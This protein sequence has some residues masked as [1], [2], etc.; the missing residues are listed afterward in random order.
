MPLDGCF[1]YK[2]KN[3]LSNTL[4]GSRVDKIYQ[5]S[6]EELVFLLRSFGASYKLLIS[7]VVS[8]P[9]VNIIDKTPEN[10]LQPPMFCML[11][12]KHFSS[13]KLVDIKQEELERILTF[14][15]ETK[16]E[17][18][19][20]VYPTLSV[21][22]IGNQTNIVL[23]D[24]NMRI[25]DC[26]RRSDI[27]SGTRLLQPGA[28]Y[29]FPERRSKLCILNET[30]EDIV[31]AV[32]N[33]GGVL[34][35]ALLNILS[36]V[37]PLVCREIAF[38]AYGDDGI[39]VEN[40]TD[41]SPLI[42]ELSNLKNS[43]MSDSSGFIIESENSKKDFSFI[44]IKQY[45]EKYKNICIQG[46]GNTLDI[47]YKERSN[48]ARINSLS[49]ELK[50]TLNNLK[51]RTER[52]INARILDLKKCEEREKYRIYGEL[53]KANLY[54]IERGSSLVTVQNYYDENYGLIDIKLNP[55][56]SPAENA[57]R[58]F[59]EYKKLCVA[60][61]T[62]GE[63]IKDGENELFYIESMIESLSRAS[64]VEELNSIK[65]EAAAAGYIRQKSVRKPKKAVLK[66]MEF[67]SPD[68][69]T[70]LVGR[71][72]REND[73]LTFK[74]AEKTDLWL[75]TKNIPGSHVVVLTEAKQV[76]EETVIFAARLAAKYSK[77]K[78]SSNVPVDCVPIKLVKK[79]NGAKP[80]MVIFTGN[81]TLFVTPHN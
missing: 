66:P 61:Q 10:P 60:H 20:T 21:E 57:G 18:G 38:S 59:K 71:N 80:G 3:E 19:D 31:F 53:L 55:T 51:N 56:L 36:G 6:K 64:T 50:K 49:S 45:G 16:N 44:E 76:P 34:S 40:I 8:A 46:I 12:R 7:A 11:L 63:L 58:Y 72:N 14:C 70:V 30:A 41:F 67:S 79:P 65:E 47:F 81:K 77:A 74:I 69:F 26:V 78:N 39:Y 9:R 32:K 4:L 52:K 68:G 24:E 17:M 28:I 25:I 27:E 73:E 1:I 35:T 23:T 15:F 62:L 37:S 5:P 22:L 75:H 42:F 33:E 43:L 29:K 54:N 48:E 13:A 2:L